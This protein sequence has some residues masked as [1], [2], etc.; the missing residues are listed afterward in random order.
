LNF[1]ISIT[2]YGAPLDLCQDCWLV[3]LESRLHYECD[4]LVQ[5]AWS[6]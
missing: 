2:R 3:M 4:M 1:S 6:H 5:C